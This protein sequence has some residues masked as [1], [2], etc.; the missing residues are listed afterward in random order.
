MSNIGW[1]EYGSPL[2]LKFFGSQTMCRQPLPAPAVIVPV[3]PVVWSAI[4]TKKPSGVSCIETRDLVAG[5]HQQ[6]VATS[7]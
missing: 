7:A 5:A 4:S 3:W 2:Q 6:D 1:N